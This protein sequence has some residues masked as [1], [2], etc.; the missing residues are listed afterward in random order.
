M[1]NTQLM[2]RIVNRIKKF[3]I[4]LLIVPILVGILSYVLTKKSAVTYTA[5]SE[6]VL[7]NFQNEK[8]TNIGSLSELLKTQDYLE[9]LNLSPDEIQILHDSLSITPNKETYDVLFALSGKNQSMVNKALTDFTNGFL[10]ESDRVYN[11]YK[12]NLQQNI[13]T[14][15][16]VEGTSSNDNGVMKQDSLL[17]RQKELLGLRQTVLKEPVSLDSSH[18]SPSKRAILGV[19][20]GIIFDIFLIVVPE[21]FREY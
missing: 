12:S 20:V 3:I 16:S 18:H 11:V 21:I 5:S 19:L 2:K 8:L 4:V 13:T 14:L 10:R 6:V 15:Q 17:D 9:K 7:G 1:D